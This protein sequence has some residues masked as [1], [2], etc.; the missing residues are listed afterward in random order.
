MH[1]IG[2]FLFYDDDGDDNNNNDNE[3]NDGKNIH[4][5]KSNLR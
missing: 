2:F 4:V 5:K 1:D 3:M